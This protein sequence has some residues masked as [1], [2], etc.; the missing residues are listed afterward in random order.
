[1]HH[2]DT[3]NKQVLRSSDAKRKDTAPRSREL[4]KD[5]PESGEPLLETPTVTRAD[6]ARRPNVHRTVAM[7]IK[8]KPAGFTAKEAGIDLQKRFHQL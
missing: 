3:V 4:E 6:D 8:V 1:M 2:M 5:G 7:G